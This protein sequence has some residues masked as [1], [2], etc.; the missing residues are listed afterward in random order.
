MRASSKA[1]VFGGNHHNTL[2]VIRSLG[3]KDIA[4]V[5]LLV[6]DDVKRTSY[7]SKSRYICELHKFSTYEDGV[8]YLIETSSS[9]TRKEVVIC[10][11]DGAASAVDLHYNVL[12]KAYYIP[13]CGKQGEISRL[14]SKEVL[15]S[16]AIEFGF[17]VPQTWVSESGLIPDG[18][19]FPCIIKPLYSKDGSKSDIQVCDTVDQLNAYFQKVHCE[20]LQIQ[21]FIEKDFEYQLIGCSICGGQIII[22]PGVSKVIRPSKTSN[23]GFLYYD[24]LD[25]SFPVK[26]VKQML[27]KMKYSGLFSAEFLRDKDGN[28]FFMEVNFRNDGN[29]I[30]ATAAGVNLP[31]IWYNSAFVE[32]QPFVSEIRPVYVMPEFDDL[33]HVIHHNISFRT[34][35]SDMRRADCYMEYDKYDKKPY[36]YRV[37]DMFGV[38]LKKVMT[39]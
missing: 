37:R 29:A 14:M 28:D 30:A 32:Q 1:F 9:L 10:C 39:R 31:F 36:L 8:Q 24:K 17:N 26:K 23:T 4:S 16:S 27:M 34:W 11:S 38:L 25:D 7:I 33:V 13:N 19:T 18:V 22:I 35:L 6:D 5:L 3:E 12:S 15:A 2:G 21:A 20:K